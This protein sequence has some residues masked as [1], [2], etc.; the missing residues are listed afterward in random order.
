ML[1]GNLGNLLSH[2]QKWV[3]E[4]SENAAKWGNGM[5]DLK[6]RIAKFEMAHIVSVRHQDSFTDAEVAKAVRYM[7]HFDGKL[8]PAVNLKLCMR[9]A[10]KS[11]GQ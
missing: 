11:M 6:S 7:I 10:K 9:A 2:A 3:R 4:N 8:P 5:S 1:Q